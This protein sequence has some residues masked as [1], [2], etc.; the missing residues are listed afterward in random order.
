MD[1]HV[2]PVTTAVVMVIALHLLHTFL[3]SG[4]SKCFTI[5]HNIHTH[6][7]TATGESTTQGD[8]QLLRG[9]QGEGVSLR[10]TSTL[11]RGVPEP[12]GAGGL[13]QRSR[14]VE[15]EEPGD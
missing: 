10:D 9:G 4:H 12:G 13:N 2:I 6:T 7:H 5:L 15:P 3:T 11:R 14:G 1:V 8:S